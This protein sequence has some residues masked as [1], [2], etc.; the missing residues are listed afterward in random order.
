MNTALNVKQPGDN[1][2][3]AFYKGKRVEVYGPTLFLA[4]EVVKNHFK[5]KK[6]WTIN[7]MIAE[8]SEGKEVIHRADF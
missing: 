8:D 5:V 7:I 1:G 4:R 6:P 2:Y 3:V